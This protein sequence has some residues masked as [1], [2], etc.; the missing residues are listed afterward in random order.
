[1]GSANFP[2]ALTQTKGT[3]LWLELSANLPHSRLS[4]FP[5]IAR[6]PLVRSAFLRAERDRRL[7]GPSGDR[8]SAEPRRRS[9]RAALPVHLPGL[10]GPGGGV[11]MA[12]TL[13]GP[14]AK[15]RPLRKIDA[16][17]RGS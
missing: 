5:K 6:D 16:A 11:A 15:R 8:P 13:T 7:S 10:C 2:P 3:D 1:M 14:K 17:M 12:H 9:G 4:C